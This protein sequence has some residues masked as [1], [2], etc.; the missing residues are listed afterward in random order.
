MRPTRARRRA[1]RAIALSPSGGHRCAADVDVAAGAFHQLLEP[2]RVFGIH[3]L[4][5]ALRRLERQVVP[6]GVLVMLGAERIGGHLALLERREFLGDLEGQRRRNG[7]IGIPPERR[8][9]DERLGQVDRVFDD[10]GQRQQVAVPP[11]V[12]GH[13][14]VGAER[15]AVA[16]HEAVL[17]VR[18]GDL[19][20]AVNPL[21]RGESLPQVLGVLR[22]VRT[23]VE[24][25]RAVGAAEEPG[26]RVGDRAAPSWDRRRA[27]CGSR[28]GARASSR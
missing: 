5:A 3:R 23:A 20:R 10:D 1:P 28:A 16:M 14:R 8:R 18:G 19:E 9:A 15:D 12:L 6:V 27:P 13:H 4:R 25:D 17:D 24:P 22:W 7:Q 11:V 21:A 26:D 2:L